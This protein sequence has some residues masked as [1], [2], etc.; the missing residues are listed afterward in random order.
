MAR[1]IKG[2]MIQLRGKYTESGETRYL[3][4]F[5]DEVVASQAERYATLDEA[6][7]VLSNEGDNAFG[8]HGRPVA[9]MGKIPEASGTVGS[10]DLNSLATRGGFK[11]GD[12]VKIVRG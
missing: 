8:K 3:G 2:W 12:S 5:G 9:S 4:E 6:L 11:S 10:V 7:D 1:E